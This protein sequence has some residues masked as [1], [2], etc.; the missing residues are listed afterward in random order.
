MATVEEL[1]IQ[2]AVA[3]KALK[4]HYES[5]ELKEYEM[6]KIIYE[7]ARQ[8]V[9]KNRHEY[10][11]KEDITKIKQR[12]LFMKYDIDYDLFLSIKKNIYTEEIEK[13]MKTYLEVRYYIDYE[14]VL[15]SKSAKYDEI[16]EQL[17][18]HK[19][20][21]IDTDMPCRKEREETLWYFRLPC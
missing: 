20:Y 15:P 8:K 2:L 10:E 21:I 3:E 13:N 7:E 17:R 14:L 11:I 12:I 1:E 18:S 4:D 6:I 19:Y 9:W 16:F 5:P